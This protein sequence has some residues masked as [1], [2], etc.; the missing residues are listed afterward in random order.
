LLVS[1]CTGGRCG[2]AGTDEDRGRSRK[3]CAEDRVWLC[4]SWV[5]IGRMIGRSGDA[6]Y[7]LHRAHGDEECGFLG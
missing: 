4:T 1:W 6:V 2:I 3:T 5:L 7:G